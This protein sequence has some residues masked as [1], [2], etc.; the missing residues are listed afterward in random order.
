MNFYKFQAFVKEYMK[1]LMV[2]VLI[3]GNLSRQESLHIIQNVLNGLSCAE[4]K[5][6][7]YERY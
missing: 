5:D 3:Q 6:V 4:I 1:E 2:Q 7:N